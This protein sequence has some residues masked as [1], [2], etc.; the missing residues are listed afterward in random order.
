MASG[1]CPDRQLRCHYSIADQI[2]ISCEATRDP[3]TRDDGPGFSASLLRAP[4]I[5]FRRTCNHG[6]RPNRER[7]AR[8]GI[9]DH[10]VVGDV[11]DRADLLQ[12]SRV[13]LKA[14]LVGR[15]AG[16]WRTGRSIWRLK[17]STCADLHRLIQNCRE[18]DEKL[19]RDGDVGADV[20]SRRSQESS[21]TLRYTV[22]DNLREAL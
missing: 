12:K 13:D 11:A 3:A 5:L 6:R 4:A 22:T 16:G 9:G 7:L 21:G 1:V 14:S 10:G 19:L 18:F 20:F 17:P 15:P 8:S 2:P